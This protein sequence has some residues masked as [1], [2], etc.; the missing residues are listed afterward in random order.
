MTNS[1]VEVVA[2]KKVFIIANPGGP[3]LANV[4]LNFGW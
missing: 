2:K 4:G 3:R 1:A